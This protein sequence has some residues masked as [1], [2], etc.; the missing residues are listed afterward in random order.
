MPRSRLR[1]GRRGLGA[2]RF[3][4]GR[5]GLADQRGDRIGRLRAD[6][7]PVPDALEIDLDHWRISD[8]VVVAERLDESPIA[9]RGVLGGNDSVVRALLRTH[10]AQSQLDH[11]VMLRCRVVGTE[12]QRSGSYQMTMSWRARVTPLAA[13]PPP[14]WGMDRRH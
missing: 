10:A 2:R 6:A 14:T 7:E 11:V 1:L 9:G 13:A 3:S 4:L 12:S 8:R 5:L